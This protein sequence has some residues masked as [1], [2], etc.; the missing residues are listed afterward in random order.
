[1]KQKRENRKQTHANTVNSSWEGSKGQFQRR[2]ANLFYSESCSG[3]SANQKQDKT[4][5]DTDLTSYTKINPKWTIDLN[6]K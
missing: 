1:M 4:K 5:Q 2:K 3:A 6:I